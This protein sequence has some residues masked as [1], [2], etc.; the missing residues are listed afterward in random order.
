VNTLRLRHTHVVLSGGLGPTHD[1][2]S[3][4]GV[5]AAFGLPIRRHAGMERFLRAVG[6]TDAAA[7]GAQGDG[8]AGDSPA[9][10]ASLTMADL[11]SGPDVRVRYLDGTEEVGNVGAGGGGGG[12]GGG[13]DDDAGVVARGYP[14]V[15][16]GNVTL[17]PGVPSILRRKWEAWQPR[18]FPRSA[19]CAPATA[20]LTVSAAEPAIA[21]T[22][23]EVAADVT[24]AGIRIGSY[25]VDDGL[26]PSR[27]PRVTLLVS[28]PSG[29][30][31]E[32]SRVAAA[33]AGRLRAA[34]LECEAGE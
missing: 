32:V 4:K 6:R 8:S 18:L 13:V 19:S 3:V 24:A 11:P 9:T 23:A 31:E 26:V 15:S 14:L 20:A 34:G 27:G 30:A 29:V 33:L 28:G 1:D 2:V 17:L 5:A 7:G 25:P 12:G 22:L 16:V 10:V 21:A